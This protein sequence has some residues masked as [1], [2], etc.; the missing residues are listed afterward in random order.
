MVVRWCL[1]LGW[2]ALIGHARAQVLNPDFSG[3]SLAPWSIS[4]TVWGQT[5]LAIVHEFDMDGP[6]PLTPGPALILGVGARVQNTGAQGV[7]VWQLAE[8]VSP[9]RYRFA[10]SWAVQATAPASAAPGALFELLVDGE[11]VGQHAAPPTIAPG[12]WW[13]E[14]A[15]EFERASAGPA[16]VAIRVTRDAPMAE[17]LLQVLDNITISG[18]CLAD[19]NNSGGT[20][21]DADVASF[22]EAWSAGAGSAD[23]NASGGTPDDADVA[24]FYERWTQGC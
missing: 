8:F 2:L 21:D 22:F 3:G 17:S 11:P 10:A 24:Y 6:G 19:F 13:G 23:V 12:F 16:Q 1:F 5:R 20:P 14:V 7:V 4:P 18:G 9:G 15:G